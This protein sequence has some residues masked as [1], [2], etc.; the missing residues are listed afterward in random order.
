MLE[1][2]C[3][4]N[5]PLGC[6]A[7]PWLQL[8]SHLRFDATRPLL[9]DLCSRG[10]WV[11]CLGKAWTLSQLPLSPGHPTRDALGYAE[12]EQMFS[13]LCQKGIQRACLD[14]ALLA[15]VSPG[16]REGATVRIQ[17]LCER[18]EL[19]ACA[20]FVEQA[21]L[22]KRVESKR[23]A[24]FE[25]AS[26]ACEG[27][28]PRGCR[29]KGV[30]KGNGQGVLMDRAEAGKEF[31]RG[32]NGG[33]M[34]SC[35]LL[36]EQYAKGRGVT[37]SRQKAAVLL[38]RGCIGGDMESCKELGLLHLSGKGVP[39]NARQGNAYLEKSCQGGVLESCTHLGWSHQEGR[40]LQ[41]N[42]NRANELFRRSCEG[43]HALGCG[44]WGWNLSKSGTKEAEAQEA[45][46]LLERACNAGISFACNV[47]GTRLERGIGT[48]IMTRKALETYAQGCAVLDED[49]CKNLGRLGSDPSHEET[50]G[51]SLKTLER[52]CS[53]GVDSACQVRA[54]IVDSP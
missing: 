18:G 12:A 5:D 46:G 22:E 33:D 13:G 1:D 26:K 40:G 45:N 27:G 51:N 15:L 30:F 44:Y 24:W 48:P 43:G 29:L 17:E 41:V 21:V 52:A 54:R 47:L 14:G 7:T 37:R 34:I 36:A 9:G 38:D 11:A 6:G 4:N 3:S 39:Q 50:L 8:E 16:K 19:R 2:A 42:L 32:C 28:V 25:L 10:H 31:N 20:Y 23:G 35:R 49:A 53:K